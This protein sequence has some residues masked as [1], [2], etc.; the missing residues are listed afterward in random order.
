MWERR[1]NVSKMQKYT[2]S[3][4]KTTLTAY[5]GFCIAQLI[6][7]KELDQEFLILLVIFAIPPF[8]FE[9]IRYR[10]NVGNE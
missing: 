5:I 7:G 9:F 2:V 6:L 3:A 4:I 10:S 8:V 1:T